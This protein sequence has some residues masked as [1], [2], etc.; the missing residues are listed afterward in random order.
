VRLSAMGMG[1]VR[2]VGRAGSGSAPIRLA[3]SRAQA[4]GARSVPDLTEEFT[5]LR[6]PCPTCWQWAFYGP[7]RSLT[8]EE[9]AISTPVRVRNAC[10]GWRA[11]PAP[12]C[13]SLSSEKLNYLKAISA[14]S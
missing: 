10:L 5:M 9:R 1:E 13:R 8:E 12:H 4:K 6:G 2:D 14:I 11:A 3:A 7:S